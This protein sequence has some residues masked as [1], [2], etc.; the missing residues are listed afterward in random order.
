M[1]IAVCDK[2]Q[3]VRQ[4]LAEWIPTFTEEA[5]RLKEFLDV[6][7]LL[8]YKGKLDMVIM[9]IG[10]KAV[11]GME[12]AAKLRE[13]S[14]AIPIFTTTKS[15]KADRSFTIKTLDGFQTIKIK[16]ILYAENEARKIILHTKNGKLAYYEKMNHLEEQ[17]GNGFFRCHRGYLVALN[18]VKGYDRREIELIN[19]E[20]ILLSRQ[21]YADF[22]QAYVDYMESEAP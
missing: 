7:E 18:K 19:G 22:I 6:E 15:G 21:K 9:D 16:D 4:E 13:K 14:Q 11:N 17:L 1:V 20:K 12:I 8:S 3:Q 5:Y 10:T 2:E